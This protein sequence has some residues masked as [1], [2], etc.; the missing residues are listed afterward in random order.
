MNALGFIET[1]GLIAAI[2]AADVMVKSA[3]VSLVKERICRKR[4]SDSGYRR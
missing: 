3:N 1:T 4:F 2:E